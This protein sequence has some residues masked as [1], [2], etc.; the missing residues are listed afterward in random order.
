MSKFII[1]SC[2]GACFIAELISYLLINNLV[3]ETGDVSACITY[4]IK[5]DGT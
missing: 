4:S 3:N 2:A 1:S 5:Q